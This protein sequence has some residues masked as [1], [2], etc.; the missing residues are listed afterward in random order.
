MRTDLDRL[1]AERK[2][3]A[4]MVM[5]NSSGNSVMNYLTGGLHL[6]GAMIVKRQGG[7]LTLIHGAMERDAAATTGMALV[8]RD[9][10]YN[11]YELLRKHEGNHL[12]AAI[13]MYSQIIAD[14]GLT[15]RLGIYGKMDVGEG[16]SLLTQL[17]DRLDQGTKLVGEYGRSLF[18]AARETKDDGELAELAEAGRLTC[19][20]VGEVQTFI[21]S[22]R[23]K[24]EVVIQATGDPLT[25]GHVKAF[26][27]E[28]LHRVGL[29]E[30]HGNIFAQ[31]RDAG[32]PHNSGDLTMPLRLGRSI[33]FDIFPQ[34]PSGYFHDMTRTWSLGYATDEVQQAWEQTKTIFDQVMAS[35]RVGEPCRSYQ[36]LTC[37]FYE[38]LGHKT[39]RSHPGTKEGYVHSLGHGI[40]L[41]VHEGPGFSHA[42]GNDAVVQPGHV[43]TIEPG[44]YYPDLPDDKGFGVRI[45][46]AV[47]FNEAGELVW[48]TNYPYDLVIPMKG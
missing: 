28:R 32:V 16:F 10:H 42:A 43:V 6:E 19:E 31:G 14:Q 21:Q 27:R 12:A 33:V 24:D 29:S 26:I 11:R 15:G 36:E 2:L 4:L 20:V 34:R 39:A 37:D 8:N 23:V 40:G 18:Q 46:D 47:A 48:L 7:P 17:A 25:I 45:E 35:L 3:D 1:M 38:G 41:D 30:D 13:D 22:H 5:G 9:E 44:L